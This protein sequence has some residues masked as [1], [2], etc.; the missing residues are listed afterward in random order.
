VDKQKFFR[1]PAETS[2]AGFQEAVE[3]L[4]SPETG[5]APG[6]TSERRKGRETG[7]SGG[8]LAPVSVDQRM[9]A[10]QS[11]GQRGETR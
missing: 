1:L 3:I 7:A 10:E 5:T 11:A 4:L 2:C 8:F 9:A 6:E